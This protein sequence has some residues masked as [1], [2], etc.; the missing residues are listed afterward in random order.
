MDEI[1]DELNVKAVELS[2]GTGDLV[3]RSLK[4][5]FRALGPVF[6]QDAPT[7]ASAIGDADEETVERLLSELATGETA[8]L[9][10][11]GREVE[12]T[13]DMVEVVETPQTGWELV[14]SGSTSIALDLEITED[15]E[16][17]GTAREIVR[18]IN[19]LR[20]AEDLELDDR[21]RL[22][23]DT[24][25]A[26]L[27]KLEERGLVTAIASEVLAESVVHD[28]E[29]AGQEITVDGVDIWIGIEKL[30]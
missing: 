21:I 29:G 8:A 6:Q 28:R 17:E 11:D 25:Q 19:D 5:N 13:E 27:K 4:P 14:T 20:K 30:G 2:D 10:V 1:A 18:A 3:E 15:L 24:R 12:I 22:S 7:V 23:L 9:A 16:L 26:L